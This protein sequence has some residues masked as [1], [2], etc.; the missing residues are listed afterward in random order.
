MRFVKHLELEYLNVFLTPAVL[1]NRVI[2]RQNF[3]VPWKSLMW[4][5][6]PVQ[7]LVFNSTV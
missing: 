1:K 2:V 3:F 5:H 6:L 4:D 7:E